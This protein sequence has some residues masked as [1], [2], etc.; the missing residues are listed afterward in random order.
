MEP[1][2]GGACPEVNLGGAGTESGGWGWGGA[3]PGGD[4]RCPGSWSAPAQ[5]APPRPTRR[6]QDVQD[7]TARDQ[8][9]LARTSLAIA[10]LR[11]ALGAALWARR[12]RRTPVGSASL[13]PGST[14]PETPRA[15]VS[16]TFGGLGCACV[17]AFASVCVLVC[18]CLC[19][20]RELCLQSWVCVQT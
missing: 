2:W 20:S 1:V 10:V 11:P 9:S 4:L 13:S 18:Q 8:R 15:R 7:P 12:P 14:S 5:Q 3:R 6:V 17:R 19:A 16:W